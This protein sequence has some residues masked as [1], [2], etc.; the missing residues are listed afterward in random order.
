MKV[1]FATGIAGCGKPKYL[2][3]F[4]EFCA[5]NKKKCKIISIGDLISSTADDVGLKIKEE[6]ILNLPKSTL[7]TLLSS[8]FEKC[9][10]E[11]SDEDVIVIST[12]ASYW[13]KTSPELAIDISYLNKINPDIYITIINDAVKILDEIYSDP[14]W[15]KDTISLEEILVWQQLEVYTSEIFSSL[16]KKDFYLIHYTYPVQTLFNLIFNENAI[17]VYPSHP[18]THFGEEQKKITK[19][20]KELRKHCIVFNPIFEEDIEKIKDKKIQEMNVNWIVRKDYKLIDQSEKVVVYFPKIVHSPGV[21]KEMAYAHDT[22]KEILLVYPSDKKS[23]F[24]TFYTD[25]TFKNVN[26]VF[27]EFKKINSKNNVKIVS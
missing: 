25:Q 26:E 6:K 11:Y 13:W 16:Q 22:H 9:M 14:K 12:H 8:V 10:K 17:K 7:K 18:M 3:E 21:E 20:L 4:E 27:N 5:K 15:V 19:F 23:P 1:V 2:E 24:T